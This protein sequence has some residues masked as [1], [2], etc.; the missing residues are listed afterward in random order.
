MNNSPKDILL[1]SNKLLHNYN[2]SLISYIFRSLDESTSDANNQTSSSNKKQQLKEL[3]IYIAVLAGIII[4]ILV[5]YAL[6]RKCVERKVIQSL[7]LEYQELIYNILNSMS[8]QIS[9]SLQNSQPERLENLRKKYGNRI[10]IKCLLKKQVENIEYTKKLEENFGDKCTICMDGFK[11]GEIIDK[12][13][14]EHLFHIKCFEKYLKGINKKDKLVCP[15]C[16]QNLLIN[17]KYIK[18]RAKQGDLKTQRII[19]KED[20]GKEIVIYNSITENE[21]EN[22]EKEKEKE[23]EKAGNKN[24]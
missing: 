19:N 16:N 18:L 23:K 7:E 5:G 21:Q 12:T 3:Y 17:K 1:I 10:L 14:C 4:I 8:S 6:Y 11:I 24:K 13:P 22:I 2:I 20:N 9:S 15:N